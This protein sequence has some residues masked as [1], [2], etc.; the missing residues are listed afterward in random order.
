M[1]ETLGFDMQSQV[2]MSEFRGAKFDVHSHWGYSFEGNNLCMK[3]LL[4]NDQLRIER[5]DWRDIKMLDFCISENLLYL[6]MVHKQ[7]TSTLCLYVLTLTGVLVT[8][9]ETEFGTYRSAQS[10]DSVH[11]VQEPHSVSLFVETYSRTSAAEMRRVELRPGR[12]LIN[13]NELAWYE[14]RCYKDLCTRGKSGERSYGVPKMAVDEMYYQVQESNRPRLLQVY[15]FNTQLS[16]EV[17]LRSAMRLGYTEEADAEL[18]SSAFCIDTRRD[19]ILVPY[20]RLRRFFDHHLILRIFS[21]NGLMERELFIWDCE[22]NRYLGLPG[23]PMLANA[24]NT[25][26]W[27]IEPIEIVVTED[28]QV[29]VTWISGSLRSGS[30]WTT[31][32]RLY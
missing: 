28:G 12:T 30:I 23:I 5:S 9:A 17:V 22:A 29:L 7:R 6:V 4:T 13:M 8:L 3:S 32:T 26:S 15:N 27:P 18:I 10:I 25:W 21:M 20:A 1:G 2:P 24:P 31:L 11:L 16:R 19:R 14:C